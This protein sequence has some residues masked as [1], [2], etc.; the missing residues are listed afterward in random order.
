MLHSIIYLVKVM[1]TQ[2]KCP[3]VLVGDRIALP[4]QVTG[5]LLREA[6]RDRLRKTPGLDPFLGSGTPF[7][8][9]RHV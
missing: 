1:I 2:Y 3:V 8:R 9:V 7:L 6:V 4:Y 5:E